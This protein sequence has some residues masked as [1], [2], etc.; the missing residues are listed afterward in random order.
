MLTGAKTHTKQGS[1]KKF[2]KPKKA[3]RVAVINH[4]FILIVAINLRAITFLN[5]ELIS[6]YISQ[7]YLN[8]WELY[9]SFE[10][11][12]KVGVIFFR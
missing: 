4:S 3:I 8:H 5:R 1:Y 12:L 6:N 11:E 2:K 10:G 7:A 9:L